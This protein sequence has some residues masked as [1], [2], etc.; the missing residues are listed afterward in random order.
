[1]LYNGLLIL[2]GITILLQPAGAVAGSTQR[3]APGHSPKLVQL[4]NL[5]QNLIAKVKHG[6]AE[7]TAFRTN[8]VYYRETLR[9]VMLANEKQAGHKLDN[10]VLMQM[11]RMAALLQSA[12]ECHTGRYI[13]C[14]AGL[15][16]ELGRQQKQL[17]QV[18]P[19]SAK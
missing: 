3:V 6:S 11:V 4:N 1:M 19:V 5:S 8:V 9:S 15:M 14:P 17:N 12:A 10:A 18:L 7:A 2:A 13:T 16:H